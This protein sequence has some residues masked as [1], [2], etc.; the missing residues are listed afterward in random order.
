MKNLVL[1]LLLGAN[2][3]GA[4]LTDKHHHKHHKHS[5]GAQHQTEGYPEV[6]VAR[7]L[8]NSI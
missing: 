3:N 2:V 1:T 6:R 5:K 4:N 7:D 8:D